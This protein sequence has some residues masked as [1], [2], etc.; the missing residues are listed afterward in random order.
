MYELETF[1]RDIIKV[2]SQ[3]MGAQLGFI[4]G[5]VPGAVYGWDFAG[6]AYDWSN[7]SR[8][9][10]KRV[11]EETGIITGSAPIKIRKTKK[12]PKNSKQ[13]KI[14]PVDGSLLSVWASPK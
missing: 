11:A 4:T 12:K 6:K 14:L 5:D 7:P 1:G 9:E 3:L 8:S 10:R 2:T 13:V